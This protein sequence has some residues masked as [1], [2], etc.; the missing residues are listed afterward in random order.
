VRLSLLV[1]LAVAHGFAPLQCQSDPEPAERRYE[2]PGE[3]LY[4]LAQRF[5]KEG[6]EAAWRDTLEY[7]IERYPNSRHAVM[8][9]DDLGKDE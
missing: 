6:N 9:R 1:A 7:L 2:T 3:A 4:D 5:K 8:A